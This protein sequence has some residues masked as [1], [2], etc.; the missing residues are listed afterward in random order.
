MSKYISLLEQI[1]NTYE[2]RIMM[3]SNDKEVGVITEQG[4]V[5]GMGLG[6]TPTNLG[7]KSD[8]SNNDTDKNNE[9]QSN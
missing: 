6:Y 2:R 8:S 4:F 5:A 9:K 1:Y 3:K 7:I